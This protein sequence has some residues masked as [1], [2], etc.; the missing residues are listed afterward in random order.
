M[1]III[2]ISGKATSGKTA[3]AQTVCNICP[4]ARR[5]P[6]AE[7]LKNKVIEEFKIPKQLVNFEKNAVVDHL[8]YPM[9]VRE[10]LIKV[11][12]MYRDIDQNFWV[13]QVYRKIGMDKDHE[14]FLIDDLRF[15][16]EAKLI[17]CWG[18]SLIRIV[19][20]GIQE[21]DDPSEK[22]LDD[23][24]SWDL[25]VDNSGSIKDLDYIAKQIIFGAGLSKY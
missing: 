20:P 21:I 4:S 14:L 12:C 8:N 1:S 24:E 18:G 23:W 3:L 22:D 17:R 2:G 25:V 13:N 19:R 7:E 11:G 9:S 15:R 16:N 10:L 6:F 5:V